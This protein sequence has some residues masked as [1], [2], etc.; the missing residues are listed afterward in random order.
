MHLKTHLSL[1]GDLSNIGVR[2]LNFEAF[3]QF[4]D[5]FG[6]IKY[7]ILGTFL[8]IC[9]QFHMFWYLCR[10]FVKELFLMKN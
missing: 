5:H 10:T 3:T 4:K 9:I 7:S 8:E 6:S 2:Y 1:E